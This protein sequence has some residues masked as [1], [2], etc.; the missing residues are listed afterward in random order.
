MVESLIRYYSKHLTFNSLVIRRNGC[1]KNFIFVILLILAGSISI[2]S[3]YFDYSY[4][5][6][7][8]IFVLLS[9]IKI[10]WYFTGQTIKH[11]YPNVYV[12]RFR[13]SQNKFD[14]M[15]L[16]KLDHYIVKYKLE[17][18]I[19]DI[20]YLLK[21]KLKDIKLPF[22]LYSSVFIALF[23]P[24]WNS[25]IDKLLELYKNNIADL[26]IIAFSILAVIFILPLFP[27]LVYNIRDNIL[28]RYSKL[29][30][31]NA[32]L[33]EYKLMNQIKK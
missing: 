28:T 32:L 8:G 19:D 7:I 3:V 24:L 23:V 11:K 14:K 22:I 20:Q 30:R 17:N 6:F 26:S 1:W 12:K 2:A 21:E 5:S 18:N 9:S 33:E 13:W 29:N 25:Y 31:L 10:S 27:P 4:L 15:V 16:E